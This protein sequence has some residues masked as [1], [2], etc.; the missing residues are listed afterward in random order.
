VEKVK[1]KFMKAL[2][3]AGGRGTR[4]RP[5]THTLNKHLVPIANK[6]MIFYA[7]EKV[8]QAGIKEVG[9][10]IPLGDKEI[11][12]VVKT[13]S[14][15]GLRIKYIEQTGGPLGLAHVI[16]ISRDFLKDEP[17]L[18]YLGDNIILSDLSEFI[19]D[20]EKNKLDCLL[21]L[22]KVKDPQR[23][24]VPEIKNGRIVRVEEKPAQP[25]SD[26]A[27]TGIYLY[28]SHVFEAVENIKPS[29]RG[30]L[31]ISDVHTYLIEHGRRVGSREI[32]GWWKDTGKPEDLL[33]ANQLVLSNLESEMKGEV[34]EGVVIQGRIKI[35]KESRIL[36]RKT[37]VR[38]PVVIGENCL[39]ENCYIGPFSSI[40]N[41]VE[42]YNTEIENS[43]IF[44]F[45]D[46]NCE[47]R[48]VDSLIG[49]NSL[50]TSAKKTFPSG[51]KLII[52]DQ[53]QVEL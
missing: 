27:V 6:P 44:D 15:W 3:T 17:F 11:E 34:E 37:V 20:F 35:G 29:A 51:H 49:T 31:E 26:F 45:S 4:L 33:E 39:I 43:I 41:N 10:V 7:L 38:G 22:S 40:G 5:I 24:G 16:K 21:A 32:T 9:I 28:N 1:T 30:E 18:F 46:I 50:I 13:G 2:I 42:I 48:I 47:A 19:K 53:S 8:A 52:G 12:A 25:K 36:G 23:F 14:K